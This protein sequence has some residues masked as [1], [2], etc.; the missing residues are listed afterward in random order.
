MI[1]FFYTFRFFLK[2]TDIVIVTCNKHILFNRLSQRGHK[3]EF[4]FNDIDMFI[5]CNKK[6]EA[7]LIQNI[8]PFVGSLSVV[9]NEK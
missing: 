1:S 9:V 3:S 4:T 8:E 6:V 2:S 7:L 5:K